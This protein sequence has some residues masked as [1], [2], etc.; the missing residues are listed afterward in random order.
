MF[1]HIHSNHIFV[2]VIPDLFTHRFSQDRFSYIFPQLFLFPCPY[3]IKNLYYFLICLWHTFLSINNS[4][5]ILFL[6][7]TFPFCIS[8]RTALSWK[9]YPFS[10]LFIHMKGSDNFPTG[11]QSLSAIFDSEELGH[12]TFL[13]LR[14]SDLH[15]IYDYWDNLAHFFPHDI[16]KIN[17]P[18]SSCID[19]KSLFDLYHIA[20]SASPHVGQ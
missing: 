12:Q 20:R 17:I 2:N 8:W 15:V 7:S 19:F 11:S 3:F 16:T 6:F 14:T 9:Y 4:N 1:L 18:N 5:P 13:S 10:L